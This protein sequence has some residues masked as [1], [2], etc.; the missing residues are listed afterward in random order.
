[1]S[2][3]ADAK[4]VN[5][6]I[7]EKAPELQAPEG[8]IIQLQRGVVDPVSGEWQVEAEIREMT[9]A[10]EEY[11]ASIQ[12]KDGIT[13]SEYMSSLL[14]RTVVRV[15]TLNVSDNP[16]VVDTVIIGDRD[17]LFLGVIK[18]TY[19]SERLFV[20]RCPHCSK[21]NDVSIDLNEDFPVATPSIDLRLPLT[22]TLRN[23]ATV[24]LRLPNA[25]DSAYVGKRATSV[26]AQNTLM[27]AR[28][29]V[30]DEDNRPADTEEWAKSL[31]V[32][33]RNNLVNALLSVEAGPSMEGVNIQCAH[34]KEEI[35]IVL[36]WISLLLS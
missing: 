34:C 13:Y 30:W 28:C 18:A 4:S 6:A 31:G 33:D 22:K 26:A 8:L 16:S 17:M 29:S 12:S 14:R 32:A 20:S 25:S 10:D 23:G 2:T 21:L 11:L 35:S 36:D 3:Q 1:M 7:S 27:L 24:R 5:S 15:G 9:G 19:G